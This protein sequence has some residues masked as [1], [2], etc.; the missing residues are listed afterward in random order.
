MSHIVHNINA[1]ESTIPEAPEHINLE[2][3]LHTQYESVP[4]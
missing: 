1:N 3:G 2:R 4:L